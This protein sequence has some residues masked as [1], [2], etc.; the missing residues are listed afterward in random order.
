MVTTVFRLSLNFRPTL[1][2]PRTCFGSFGLLGLDFFF[3]FFLFDLFLRSLGLYFI[4]FRL[5]LGS[6]FPLLGLLRLLSLLLVTICQIPCNGTRLFL[7]AWYNGAR[8]A[9][10]GD[11]LN[12]GSI[13]QI[14]RRVFLSFTPSVFEQPVRGKLVRIRQELNGRVTDVHHRLVEL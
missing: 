2:L 5:S 12:F 9:A 13:R 11:V 4:L 1:T 8:P 6:T 7:D 10:Y 3:A 14:H